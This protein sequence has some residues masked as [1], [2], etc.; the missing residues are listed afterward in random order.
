M[1]HIHLGVLPRSRSWKAVVAML[2]DHAAD[3][4]VIAQAAVAAER[5]LSRAAY[6]ETYV[7]TIRLLAMIPQ[8][9]RSEHFGRR[10]RSLGVD[11]SDDAGFADLVSSVAR[12]LDAHARRHGRSDFGTLAARA[13]IGALTSQVGDH[14]P[15]L[16]GADA[17]DVR[18]GTARLATPRGFS[19]AARAYFG[20]LLGDSLSSWLDRTLATHVGPGR[21]FPD[22]AG[23]AAFDEALASYC[24]EATLII[25][26]FSA[27]WQAA[28]LRRVGTI[29]TA[30]ARV[31]GAVAFKKIGEELRIKRRDHDDA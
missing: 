24:A 13:L 23:R 15:A 25:G 11:A 20:K 6:D 31:Y 21:R 19:R 5:D 22:I 16:F 8:A 27:G 1:G 4:L 30:E 14:L 29:G 10:L 3:D 12:H 18:I 2:E 26:E 17:E 9:A 7:E 28:T